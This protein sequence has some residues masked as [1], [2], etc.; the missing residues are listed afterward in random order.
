MRMIALPTLRF[1]PV[2]RALRK[3]LIP[4]LS[5]LQPAGYRCQCV[6]LEDVSA[7]N[8]PYS[9]VSGGLVLVDVVDGPNTFPV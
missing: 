8:L 7:S 4:R 3:T 9:H 5:L 1:T 6:R 2:D